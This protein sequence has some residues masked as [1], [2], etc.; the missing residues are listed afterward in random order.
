MHD[1]SAALIP[2]EISSN[3]PFVLI[4]TGTWCISL[5]PFNHTLLTGDELKQDCLC[6]L[7]SRGKQIKASR[8]FAGNYHELEIKKLSEHFSKPLE[9]YSTVKFDEE[10]IV[11]NKSELNWRDYNN[12]EDAYHQLMANIIS[13]QV[14]S[15]NLV[16]KGTSV[17]KLFVDGGF[18]KNTLYMHLLAKSYP[19]LEVS[20]ASVPQASALGAALVIHD[21]WNTKN[22]LYADKGY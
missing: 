16:L 14:K 13:Q 2:Y 19:D 18:S 20:A 3:A 21:K 6:Y 9:Y 12:Y 8:L 15:T 1:S 17:K 5:N 7:S 4:S 11:E 22:P 10:I